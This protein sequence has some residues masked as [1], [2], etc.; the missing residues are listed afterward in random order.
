MINSS[1]TKR[2]SYCGTTKRVRYCSKI[3]KF[4]QYG[5]AD[6]GGFLGFIAKFFVFLRFGETGA[7][8]LID[9]KP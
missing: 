3:K 2:V 6:V 4:I 5:E 7:N 9:T 8:T 1:S